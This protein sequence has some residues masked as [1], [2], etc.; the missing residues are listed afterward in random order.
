MTY[1]EF[2]ETKIANL[3]ILVMVNKH[4]VALNVSMYNTLA[5][6][7]EVHD[8]NVVRYLEPLLPG[9]INLLLTKVQHVVE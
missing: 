9:E 7:V 8:S 4:V 2:S 5:V 1:G 6:H 3:H